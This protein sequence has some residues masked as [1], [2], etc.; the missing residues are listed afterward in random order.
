MPSRGSTVDSFDQTLKELTPSGFPITSKL[1]FGFVGLLTSAI[2]AYL[3]T[4]KFFSVSLSYYPIFLGTIVICAI[5]LATTYNKL[6]LDEFG[7]VMERKKRFGEEESELYGRREAAAYSMFITNLIYVGCAALLSFV[8]LPRFN[9]DL[10]TYV[11]YVVV[12]ILSGVFAF[13][14]GYGFF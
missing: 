2:P 12:S 6:A 8:I 4:S 7:R 10:P 5:L 13:G 3:F 9:I 14:C 1:C 11:I